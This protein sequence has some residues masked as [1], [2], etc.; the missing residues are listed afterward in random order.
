MAPAA[1]LAKQTPGLHT[2]PKSP[3]PSSRAARESGF[4]KPNFRGD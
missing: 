4:S 3:T 2:T 1:S